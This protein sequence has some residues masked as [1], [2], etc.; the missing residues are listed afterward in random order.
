MPVY[1]WKSHNKIHFGEEL[2]QQYISHS[3]TSAAFFF[4][5]ISR[6]PTTVGVGKC[7]P[8]AREDQDNNFAMGCP[9]TGFEDLCDILC[10]YSM[11]KKAHL[12]HITKSNNNSSWYM[13]DQMSTFIASQSAVIYCHQA[14]RNIFSYFVIRFKMVDLQPKYLH[15]FLKALFSGSY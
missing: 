14:I 15:I 6:Q 12:P 7:L 4:L 11:C 5:F 2:L 8:W 10:Y 3:D 13:S 9:V 1:K